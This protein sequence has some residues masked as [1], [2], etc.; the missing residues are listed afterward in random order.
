[1]R[2]LA[3]RSDLRISA[4]SEI[5]AGLPIG[6]DVTQD[7]A[8]SDIRVD[9]AASRNR[10]RKGRNIMGSVGVA[11]PQ[12]SGCRRWQRHNSREIDGF[13]A[14]KPS[15][16]PS[17]GMHSAIPFMQSAMSA[18]AQGCR[19]FARVL[20]VTSPVG[21]LTS[22]GERDSSDWILDVNKPR[23]LILPCNSSAKPTVSYRH[24]QG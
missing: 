1:M 20:L 14:P 18:A 4:E 23:P 3:C 16:T 2:R 5:G 10:D 13:S 24:L 7:G 19:C 22:S 8:A 9:T 15:T 12:H 11:K 6:T 17:P 21:V